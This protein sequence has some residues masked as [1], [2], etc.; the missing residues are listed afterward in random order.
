MRQTK[1]LTAIIERE[2][3]GYVALCPELDIAS[4]GDTIEQARNN[5]V[6]A[7]ELFFEMAAPSEIEQRLHTEVFVTR[8]EVSVG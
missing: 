6:E 8:L 5:L 3:D 7:L 4:Q 2:G 1:Q